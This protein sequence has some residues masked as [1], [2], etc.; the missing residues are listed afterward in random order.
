MWGSLGLCWLALSAVALGQEDAA[1]EA[2]HA[3]L[4]DLRAQFVEALNGR[5]FGKLEPLLAESFTFVSVDNRKFS[6][7]EELKPY[8]ESLF[9][10]ENAVL[11]SMT[12]APE[13]DEKTF[14]FGP[15]YGMAQGSSQDVYE[16]KVLGRREMPSRWTAV[17]HK[18][19]DQWKVSHVH[20]SAN[21]LDNP[22]TAA[23]RKASSAKAGMALLVGLVAGAVLGWLLGKG[24]RKAASMGNE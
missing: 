1:R 15:D 13:A 21:V 19:G 8:W 12:A 18:T 5:D 16:F 3:A 6:G 2:D 23:M 9:T 4:R 11:N 24:R 17:V 20:M 7:I 10:G 14:F 22:V